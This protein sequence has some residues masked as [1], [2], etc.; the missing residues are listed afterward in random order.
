MT[1]RELL[2]LADSGAVARAAAKLMM[3]A[4]GRAVRARGRFDVVLSGGSTPRALYHLLASEFA[5]VMPWSQT[6]VWFGDERLSLI[7]I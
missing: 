6:H 3:E 2:V 7:H 1:G 4:A 5:T